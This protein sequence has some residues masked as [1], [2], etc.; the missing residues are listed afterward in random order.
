[1]KTN[2]VVFFWQRRRSGF[3]RKMDGLIS[4]SV[5]SLFTLAFLN[6]I[7]D[8]SS[9]ATFMG[10]FKFYS[11]T[12]AQAQCKARCITMVRENEIIYYLLDFFLLSA[13]FFSTVSKKSM[14]ISCS[15]LTDYARFFSIAFQKNARSQLTG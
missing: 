2:L 9:Y 4:L 8:V 12:Y 7:G 13:R 1:M 11:Y 15:S 6:I 3:D 14:M 5:W 10:S